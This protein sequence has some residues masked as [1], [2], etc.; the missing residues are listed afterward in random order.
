MKLVYSFTTKMGNYTD[1][2]WVVIYYKASM[3]KAKSL[4]YKIKLYGCD[5]IYNNLKDDIDEFVSI[6]NEEFILTD[7]LKMHIHSKENLDCITIDGDVILESPLNLPTDCDVLFETKLLNTKNKKFKRY[8][9][10]FKKYDAVNHV[11]YFDYNGLHASNV[12]ILKFNTQPTKD[13]LLKS[14]YSFRKYY[15]ENIEPFENLTEWN[16]PSIIVCEYYFTRVMN[17]NNISYKFCSDSNDYVHYA[18][19]TKFEQKFF[20]H[21]NSIFNKSII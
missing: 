11:E 15:L 12:G 3:R 18:S 10:I 4:G 1:N 7:D 21:I 14:Y 17:A 16:D 20:N 2:D 5:F 6:Q 9:D 19:E 8:M 13:L